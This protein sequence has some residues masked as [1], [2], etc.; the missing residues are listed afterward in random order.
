MKKTRVENVQKIELSSDK[1]ISEAV[2]KLASPFISACGDDDEMKNHIVS[3]AVTGWN[4]SLYPEKDG[5]YSEKIRK[6]I[7]SDIQ[8][9]KKPV[10]ISFVE[11]I[12]K[13]KQAEYP[14]IKK[15]I[16]SFNISFSN[17]GLKLELRALPIKPVI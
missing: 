3:L 5:N 11:Q 10:L 17:E 12:I 15:G 9:E 8:E 16:T 2:I 7:A 6:N 1:D 14:D 13:Q 4:L